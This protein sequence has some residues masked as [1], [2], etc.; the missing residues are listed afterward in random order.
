MAT[1]N[2]VDTS[3]H[4][5]SFTGDWLLR[6]GGVPAGG[7]RTSG[8]AWAESARDARW[9]V[10]LQ[11]P[12]PG[13]KGFPLREWRAPGWQVWLLGELYGTGNPSAQEATILAVVQ[14]D[15]PA[16]DLNG[17]FLLL[18]WDANRG[19]W[20]A[21]T[22]RFGTIHAYYA[23]GAGKTA[24]GTCFRTVAAVASAGELD[25]SALAGFFGFGFFPE[26]RTFYRDVRVLRRATHTVLDAG[27]QVLASKRYWEWRHVPDERRSYDDTVDE[28]GARFGVVMRELLA[29]GR[30]AVPI[31]GGLDSRS[32]VAEVR[33]E[34]REAR[35][36]KQGGRLWSY[37]YGYGEDSV[38]TRIAREVAGAR[39]L[40]F[41]AFTIKPY[42]FERLETVLGAVEGFQDVTQC[43]QAFVMEELG[44]QADYVIAAHWGDVW[45]DEMG[46]HR[47]MKDE[48]GNLK[49]GSG[50]GEVVEHTVKKMA[51]RGRTWLLEKLCTPHL[52][53]ESPEGRLREFAAEG[54]APLGHLEDLDF[55]V[56]AFKTDH[57]S[58]RWTLASLRMFQPGAFP[59]LPF[60][61]TRLADFFCTVPTGFV[62]GRRLQIDYLKRFAPE[63]ARIDWQPHGANLYRYDHFDPLRL[64]RR[65]ANKA[66]RVLKGTK[67][68]ERNWEVQFGGEAGR[69]GLHRWLQRPGL[70][71]HDFVAKPAVESLLERFHADPLGEGRG[72][73]VSMLLTFSAWLETQSM[74]TP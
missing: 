60:Y 22:D 64:A 13:W 38:E 25:W 66:G 1:S 43:R 3:T 26:D 40:P 63:L 52:G 32:T 23:Q 65:V 53:P 35:G 9:E 33:E 58:F 41:Q 46:L 71:L 73:T 59:R 4:T 16:S 74:P 67:V 36:E 21:W 44:A 30:V 7:G 27:G 37:S 55:R 18:A 11:S 20:H 56:K 28:F 50:D 34:R 47:G 6:F 29:K 5:V 15:R 19:E 42:L 12:A 57:W 39:G 45:L 2:M 62:A 69:A 61:D 54:L 70:R 31:S 24:L 8:G 72:Y 68:L 48:S 10:R 14:G 49:R 51:K 17:H